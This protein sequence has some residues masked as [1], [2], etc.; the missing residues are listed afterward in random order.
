MYCG[1]LNNAYRAPAQCLAES[2][3]AGKV[4]VIIVISIDSARSQS[5]SFPENRILSS[6]KKFSPLGLIV[7]LDLLLWLWQFIC[8]RDAHC[9]SLN[10]ISV[11]ESWK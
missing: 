7:V 4:N 1:R 8:T 6:R 5:Y 10:I 9:L 3:H 11:T 2:K